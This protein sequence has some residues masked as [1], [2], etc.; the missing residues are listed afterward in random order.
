M[1]L[2]RDNRVGFLLALSMALMHGGF[3]ECYSQQPSLATHRKSYFLNTGPGIKYVG[4]RV[5]ARCHAGIYREY[6]RTAM[7]RSMTLPGD[8]S[9]PKPR[10]PVRIHNAK[11]DRDY[12][13]F[14]KGSDLYQSES[15]TAP[16]GS[17]VFPTHTGLP[18]LWVREKTASAIWSGKE[19]ILS[20]PRFPITGRLRPGNFRRVTISGIWAL[21][22]SRRSPAWFVTVDARN[23]CRGAKVFIET[24]HLKNWRSDARTATGR[25]SF[26]WRSERRARRCAGQ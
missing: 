26:M 22:G 23:P 20:R 3:G 14:C 13:M 5:C 6:V 4:S 19:T 1:V 15:K 25:D 8:P 24:R 7:G 10:S 18:M 11:L 17:E 9:L 12:E 21:T 16:D 2:G